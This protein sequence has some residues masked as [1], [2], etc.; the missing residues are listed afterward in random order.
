MGAKVL[1]IGAGASHGARE[2]HVVRP[3]L[4]GQLLEHVRNAY[5]WF[6]QDV[7]FCEL[8]YLL[9][10]FQKI[11]ENLKKEHN[12]EKFLASL[13]QD[14]RMLVNKLLV[15]YMHDWKPLGQDFGFNDVEED[16]YDKII[17]ELNFKGETWEVISLNYDIL[18]EKALVRNN[19]GVFYDE[20]GSACSRE[21]GKTVM[22]LKPHGSVNFFRSSQ[23]RVE[24]GII[25]VKR[26]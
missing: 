7:R 22:F 13:K 25:R 19:L 26:R 20:L 3:P 21:Y 2:G 17:H 15:L 24:W 12:F 8:E 5:D 9:V 11:F 4:G 6:A 10:R 1:F 23:E 18:F 14:E 16:L